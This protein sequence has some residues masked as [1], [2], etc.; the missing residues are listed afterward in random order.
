MIRLPNKP[1]LPIVE[2]IPGLWEVKDA[3]QPTDFFAPTGLYHMNEPSAGSALP[4]DPSITKSLRAMGVPPNMGGDLP[5]YPG[6]SGKETIR[7]KFAIVALK[8]LLM[9]RRLLEVKEIAIASY[10]LADAMLEARKK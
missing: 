6:D 1:L 3:Y 10:E 8:G 9:S 7:D 5:L 4:L 2:V